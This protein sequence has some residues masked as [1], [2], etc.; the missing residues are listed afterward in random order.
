ML[1]LSVCLSQRGFHYCWYCFTDI[2]AFW[3][4]GLRNTKKHFQ[5]EKLEVND[6]CYR[7]ASHKLLSSINVCV[8]CVKI[9]VYQNARRWLRCLSLSITFNQTKSCIQR[10]HKFLNQSCRLISFVVFWWLPRFRRN[11]SPP[12]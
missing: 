6:L 3:I 12:S 8:N 4:K 7:V 11:L 2:A 5:Q 1:C 10:Q 9:L